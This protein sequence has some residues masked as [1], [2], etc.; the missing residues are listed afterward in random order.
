MIPIGEFKLKKKSLSI[1]C[2]LLIF[3]CSCSSEATVEESTLSSSTVTT[4]SSSLSVNT[5]SDEITTSTKSQNISENQI[6]NENDEIEKII[7]YIKQNN[8]DCGSFYDFDKDGFPE[9]TQQTCGE[10]NE[11][12][13]YG[14]YCLETDPPEFMGWI[15]A[16]NNNLVLYVD[17]QTHQYF[18][19]GTS[20][21]IP[22]GSSS[23][24]TT[25]SYKFLGKNLIEKVISEKDL[26][27]FEKIEELNFEPQ[28]SYSDEDLESK[29]REALKK[30]PDLTT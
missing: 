18:Y 24:E 29:V 30:Y 25:F 4:V 19:V 5:D 9:L 26:A 12:I 23:T 2:M 13:S 16:W 21:I 6:S 27:Q 14:I 1:L 7:D 11:Q 22:Q 17:N 28:W 8:I 3:L 15:S 10:F 20:V